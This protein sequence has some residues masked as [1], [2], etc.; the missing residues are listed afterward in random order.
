MV[1]TG[2]YE[3]AIPGDEQSNVHV[4]MKSIGKHFDSDVDIGHFF[5]V[6]GVAMAAIVTNNLLGKK[7]SVIDVKIIQGLEGFDVGCLAAVAI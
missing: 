2:S 5:V 6:G 4:V 3:V 7:V 1:W